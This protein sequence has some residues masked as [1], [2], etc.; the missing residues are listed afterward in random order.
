[1]LILRSGLR[2]KSYSPIGRATVVGSPPHLAAMARHMVVFCN[3]MKFP[4]HRRA[5]PPLVAPNR[6]VA[7]RRP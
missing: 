6:E 4:P 3:E 1:M 7:R 2:S 5:S